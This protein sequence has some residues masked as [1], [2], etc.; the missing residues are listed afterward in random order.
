MT[1]VDT[2]ILIRYIVADERDPQTGIATDFVEKTCS[3]SDPAIVTQVVLAELAW[4]LD[5]RY[6]FP[7]ADILAAVDALLQSPNILFDGEEEVL[8]ALQ[9]CRDSRAGLADCLIAARANALDAG[10]VVT[11]DQDAARTPGFRLLE[12]GA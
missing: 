7:K 2:N 11:F 4:T 8:A 6:R 5:T 3:A 1:V 12:A 10:P 9:A